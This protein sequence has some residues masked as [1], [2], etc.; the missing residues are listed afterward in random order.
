MSSVAEYNTFNVQDE[1]KTLTYDEIVDLQRVNSIPIDIAIYNEVNDFNL[2]TI[3]RNAAI[4]GFRT[5]YLIGNKRYDRRG[6]V[7]AHHYVN[8]VHCH[9]FYV[10]AGKVRSRQ[11]VALEC[12]EH[13]PVEWRP[14]IVEPI[15]QFEFHEND[16]L[17]MGLE[18]S[19]VP[20]ED[21]RSGFAMVY[22][23]QRGVLRSL[24]AGVA[25]GI[26]MYEASTQWNNR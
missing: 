26:A 12:I 25:S 1:Y 18:T 5:V 16:C 8:I 23:P 9:S 6:T 17:L 15:N 3:I 11:R 22:I 19:G 10:F 13:V 20:L 14:E 21:I 7:G 24:N 2:A 4:F